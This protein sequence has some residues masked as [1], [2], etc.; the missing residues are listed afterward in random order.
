MVVPPRLAVIGE[1]AFA[2]IEDGLDLGV[3]QIVDGQ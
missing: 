2:L 1:P 3:A